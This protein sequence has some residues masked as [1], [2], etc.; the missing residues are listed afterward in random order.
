MIDIQTISLLDILPAS[1]RRDSNIQASAAAFDKEHREV[2]TAISQLLLYSNLDN[3]PEA[4]IDLLAW[5]KHVDFYDQS[6]PIEK[7]RELVRQADLMHKYKGTPWAVD[8]VVSTAFDD[9]FVSEWFEYGGDPFYF[10][11][12]TT[13]RMT[14]A[15]RYTEIIRAIKSAKNTRSRLETITIRRDN[16]MNLYIGGTVTTLKIHTIKPIGGGMLGA[17]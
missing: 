12:T 11:V 13:D 7:K 15:K 2:S 1:L 3:Q 4:I 9:G 14:D 5:Q 17:I 8:E 10:K 16:K 6:L